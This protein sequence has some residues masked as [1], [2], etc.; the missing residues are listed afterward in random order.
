MQKKIIV[1]GATGLIGSELVAEL[2][3]NNYHVT[4][5]SR[6]PIS[7]KTKL[8]QADEWVKWTFDS[9]DDWAS[10]VDGAFGIIHLA[11]ANLFGKRWSNSYKKELLDSR[12]LGSRSLVEAI[13]KSKQKP[14]VLVSGSAIG[15]YGDTADKNIDE[16]S[17]PGKD[18][19][20]NVCESWENE[21]FLA[22]NSGVRVALVRT[23]IVLDT[24]DGAL[25][26]LL[27]PF[28]MFVGGPVL[29]GSQYFS[30]IHIKDEVGIILLALENESVSGA[31]N[32][33]APNPLT[34]TEFSQSLG[35]ALSRP[36]WAAVPGFALKLLLGEVAGILTGGQ[37]VL[38][39]KAI[40]CGYKFKFPDCEIAI[41]DLIN[42]KK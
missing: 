25:K 36:S 26:Q 7:A 16:T 31:I 11:G 20:A 28:K 18:F 23:G 21:S 39:N 29:P 34:N 13:R 6:D 40:S 1:T 42:R 12:V 32:A 24:N 22:V 8:P 2:K 4:V 19:L 35:R 30:W 3:S 10:H 17:E 14:S 33:T 15:I 9:N 38:P 41:R 37:K 5:F 27:L